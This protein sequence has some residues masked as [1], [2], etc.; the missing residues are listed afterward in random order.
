[1]KRLSVQCSVLALVLTLALSAVA[2]P[3]SENITLYHGTSVNGISLPAG[4]YVVKYDFQGSNAQVKFM[5]GNKEVASTT[6]QAKTLSSKVP[7]N[8]VVLNNQ[9]GSI[10]E[11]DFGGKDTAITFQS[12]SAMNAE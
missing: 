11:I 7:A 10:V 9:D 5:E 6:G 3:K 4:S 2:K 8:Q 12:P 1:M